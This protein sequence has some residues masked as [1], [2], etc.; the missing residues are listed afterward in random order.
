MVNAHFLTANIIQSSRN[1]GNGDHIKLQRDRNS[2][3]II[4]PADNAS[5]QDSS[6][7]LP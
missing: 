4:K 2:Y 1:H 3:H 5:T 7:G 6:H